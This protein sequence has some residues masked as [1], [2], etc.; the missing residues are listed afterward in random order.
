[1]NGSDYFHGHHKV[2]GVKYLVIL[3]AGIV[4]KDKLKLFQST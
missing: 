1:M 4:L 2:P 3:C